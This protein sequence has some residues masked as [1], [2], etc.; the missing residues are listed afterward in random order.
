MLENVRA[1]LGQLIVPLAGETLIVGVSGGVDSL[2][3]L[4]TLLLLKDSF[5]YELHIATFDHGLRGD[6]GQADVAFVQQFCHTLRHPGYNR[7]R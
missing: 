3:L 4:K 1:M 6:A 2:V 5:A 7:Q